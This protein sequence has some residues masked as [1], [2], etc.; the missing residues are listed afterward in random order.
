VGFVHKVKQSGF[1]G[2]FWIEKKLATINLV[3]GVSVY[4]EELIKIKDVE[5]RVW[6]FWRSKPAAAIRKNLKIF[7]IKKNSKI[8]YL[9]CGS[10]TTCSHYSDIVGMGG[11]VYAIDIAEKPMRDMIKL[12]ES[13][14]NIVP[15]LADSRKPEEYLNLVVEK[16][17]VVYCDVA[18]PDEIELFIRNSKMFLKPNGFGMIAVKS[19]SIDVLKKPKEVYRETRVKLEEIFEVL[20]F[21]ELDPYDK[22]HGFFVTKFK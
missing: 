8:L 12:A 15:I 21:V 1:E 7:P 22:D 14:G 13:R 10:G 9:G 20:D 19:R 17:D 18:S 3:P 4:G 2:I 11:L 6:D 16:V 5:Y